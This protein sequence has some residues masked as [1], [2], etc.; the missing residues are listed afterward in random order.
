MY[1]SSVLKSYYNDYIRD[2][3]IVFLLLLPLI[4]CNAITLFVGHGLNLAQ[5]SDLANNFFYFSNLLIGIYPIALCL[6][7][8]YYIA[9]KHGVNAMVVVPYS[10][11]L[12]I[13]VSVPNELVSAQSGLPNNPLIALL[14]AMISAICC[15]SFRLFPLDPSRIDFVNTL[16]KHVLHFFCFLLFTVALAKLTKIIIALSEYVRHDLSLNPLTF[17]GGLSYQFILGLL[18]AIGI[19]GHNF[20]FRAK[21]Q[22]FENT[23]QNIA[24]WQAGEASLNVL[25]QGFYDAFLSMG[26]SGNTISLLLCVLLFSKE[27][28][29]ITLALSAL[30]LVIFNINELLLF[31]LP[32]IFNPILII[33]FVLV[34]LVSFVVVYGAITFGLVNP[35]STIVDWMTPPFISGYIATQHS[36]SGVLLQV[37]VVIIGIGIYRPFYLHYVGRSQ[38]NNMTISRQHELDRSTLKSFLGD[39]NQAM[40]SYINKHDISRRVS[41]MLSRGEFI[42]HYQPQVHLNNEHCLSFESLIRYKDPEG[43]LWP[44]VFIQDFQQL[45]AIKQLDQMVI[46]LVLIDIQKM[47]LEK[48]CKVAINVSAET[49]SDKHIVAYIVERLSYYDISPQVLEI[50]ITEEAII[51]NDKQVSENIA[52]LQALGIT[53]A[54]DDFGSGY[55]SFPHLLKFNFDKVKLDR[56]LLFNIENEREKSLYQLLAKIS[57]VTGCVLVA[58]GVETEAEKHFVQ[59][60]GIDICQGFY[61]AKPMPLDNALAWTKTVALK[62]ENVTKQDCFSI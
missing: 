41:R 21:Q 10:L 14:A 52:V 49:I 61:F 36:L 26:G 27:K 62:D 19:N 13:A 8:S 57:E 31:G 25:G 60:C 22:L 2:I 55:A 4:I 15:I 40:S 20:L 12:F 5:L 56:S 28:R 54:I 53:I 44:P 35:V 1:K 32:I 51:D 45:G 39:V 48:N 47:P 43:K 29:H 42:M 50:E 24:D 37:V 34:P 30:P 46:D 11:L 17:Y 23:Q 33:P 7:T 16:Y 38:N 58:E 9:T 3:S 59:Q 6:I 18:G